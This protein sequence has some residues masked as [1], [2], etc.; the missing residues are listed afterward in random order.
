LFAFNSNEIPRTITDPCRSWLAIA[1][2]ACLF[3]LLAPY[4]DLS[5]ALNPRQA[6]KLITI[7]LI[8]RP[9][10]NISSLNLNLEPCGFHGLTQR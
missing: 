1:E 3:S 8:N 9:Q 7:P 5:Q 2:A 10:Y 6:T 4:P